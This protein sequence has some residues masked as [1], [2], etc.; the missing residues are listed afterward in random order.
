MWKPTVSSDEIW[1]SAKGSHW[2]KHKYIAIKNGRYIYPSDINSRKTHKNKLTDRSPSGNAKTLKDLEEDEIRETERSYG[3][4]RSA[5]T[6]EQTHERKAKAA[7]SD[8]TEKADKILRLA[9]EN[10]RTGT[11]KNDYKILSES[12]KLK[13]A[14]KKK[15]LE[16]ALAAGASRNKEKHTKDV[17]RHIDSRYTGDKTSKNK[18][19]KEGIEMKRYQNENRAERIEVE[20]RFG[21]Y[22]YRNHRKGK[23]GKF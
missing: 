4:E 8:I 12:F 11:N 2:G 3:M 9:K 22:T 1:H 21:G 17:E 14:K 20:K 10:R 23:G 6:A 5:Y 7:S 19:L 18:I 16:K 13:K 15:K